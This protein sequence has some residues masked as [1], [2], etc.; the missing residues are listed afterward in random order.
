MVPYLIV[1]ID[2]LSVIQSTGKK[3]W[4]LLLRCPSWASTSAIRINGISV[5]GRI[6][7]GSYYEIGPRLW[8]E[9]DLVDY[10][11]G[12]ELRFEHIDDPRPEYHGVGAILYGPYML[13]SLGGN[14]SVEL[15]GDVKALSDWIKR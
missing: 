8:H 4:S 6:Q 15:L 12:M 5:Q 14:L 13:A 2:P 3:P 1:V 9:G 7:P 11:F 10:H